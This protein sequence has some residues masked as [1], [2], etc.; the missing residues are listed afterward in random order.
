LDRLVATIV[1]QELVDPAFEHG[2]FAIVGL[3]QVAQ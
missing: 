3:D 1:V 2:D